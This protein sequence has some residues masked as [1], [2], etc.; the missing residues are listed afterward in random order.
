MF[1]VRAGL[2]VILE[3]TMTIALFYVMHL[4]IAVTLVL[5]RPRLIS[6]I[7]RERPQR[8]HSKRN[9]KRHLYKNHRH[10]NPHHRNRWFA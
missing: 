6:A 8:R 9:L 4:F 2:S 10:R 3:M 7:L 1:V 5:T